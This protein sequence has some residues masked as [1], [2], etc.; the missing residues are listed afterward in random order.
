[1][2]LLITE[3]IQVD[4]FAPAIKCLLDFMEGEKSNGRRKLGKKKAME[5]KVEWK[6]YWTL[7]CL[8]CAFQFSVVKI[9]MGN[10]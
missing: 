3:I 9:K 10:Q 1:L 4:F 8:L 7:A 6:G 2:L 5:E